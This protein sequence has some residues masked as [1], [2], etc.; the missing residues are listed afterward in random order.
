MSN[1]GDSSDVASSASAGRRALGPLGWFIAFVL[2][3]YGPFAALWW[4]GAISIPALIV[5][6]LAGAAV[7]I[8]MV[9]VLAQTNHEPYQIWLVLLFASAMWGLASLVFTIGATHQ[10][11]T[12]RALLIWRIAGWLFGVMLLIDLLL[13]ISVFHLRRL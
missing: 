5:Y 11:W 8:G 7:Q 10:I 6:F 4:L 2:F 1:D 13:A 3:P 12:R 9:S